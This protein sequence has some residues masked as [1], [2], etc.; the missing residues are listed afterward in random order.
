M[1]LACGKRCAFP[2]ASATTATGIL[3]PFGSARTQR[4]GYSHEERR[5][6]L[7]RHARGFAQQL[8]AARREARRVRRAGDEVQEAAIVYQLCMLC[9]KHGLV[10]PGSSEQ[11]LA[12]R[13]AS[14]R[15]AAR[16]ARAGVLWGRHYGVDPFTGLEALARMAE[17]GHRPMLAGASIG[18]RRFVEQMRAFVYQEMLEQVVAGLGACPVEED[19]PEATLRELWHRRKARSLGE[20]VESVRE[21][22]AAGTLVCPEATVA[23]RWPSAD[24]SRADRTLAAILDSQ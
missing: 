12:F 5:A 15:A 10:E 4:S 7:L 8:E 21:E 11:W 14:V 20:M 22:I 13:R 3:S 24:L 6:A 2:T 18:A 16:V 23:P 1:R 9:E 19:P 17:R